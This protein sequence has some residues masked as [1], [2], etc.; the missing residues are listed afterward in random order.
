M[1]YAVDRV[2]VEHH[3]DA[4]TIGIMPWQFQAWTQQTTL[5]NDHEGRNQ[6]AC[7]PMHVDSL[8]TPSCVTTGNMM[9]VCT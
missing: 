6:Y 5:N 1:I 3:D 2:V 4:K 8:L 9:W 7:L